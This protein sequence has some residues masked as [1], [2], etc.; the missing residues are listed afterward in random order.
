MNNIHSS[1]AADYTFARNTTVK[2]KNI[3]TG[4]ETTINVSKGMGLKELSSL[5]SK[6][7][8]SVFK[9]NETFQISYTRK[10]EQGKN[11]NV[12]VHV[13]FTEAFFD[14]NTKFSTVNEQNNKFFSGNNGNIGIKHINIEEAFIT[15]NASHNIESIRSTPDGK[16]SLS[17]NNKEVDINSRNFPKL[18]TSLLKEI[19]NNPDLGANSIEYKT[20]ALLN[21]KG[22]KFCLGKTSFGF[23]SIQEAIDMFQSYDNFLNDKPFHHKPILSNNINNKTYLWI[24]F[25]GKKYLDPESN[26][27]RDKA[28]ILSCFH[29]ISPGASANWAVGDS[30]ALKQSRILSLVLKGDLSQYGFHHSTDKGDISKF[31]EAIKL[32]TKDIMNLTLFSTSESIDFIKCIQENFADKYNLNLDPILDKVYHEAISANPLKEKSLRSD[33]KALGLEHKPMSYGEIF[34]AFVQD[35][36]SAFTAFGDYSDIAI[37]Q[38]NNGKLASTATEHLVQV[39]MNQKTGLENIKQALVNTPMDI[40]IILDEVSPQELEVKHLF[41]MDKEGNMQPLVLVGGKDTAGNYSYMDPTTERIYTGKNLDQLVKNYAQESDLPEGKI[42]SKIGQAK[43]I[44]IPFKTF[45]AVINMTE[46]A[47]MVAGILSSILPGGQYIGL[48]TLG[49]ATT[50]A[51]TKIGIKISNGEKIKNSDIYDLTTQLALLTGAGL[52][53]LGQTASTTANISNK[54]RV[55]QQ[56]A[57]DMGTALSTLGQTM[58]TL[59]D[60]FFMAKFLEEKNPEAFMELLGNFSSQVA[61]L[62]VVSSTR[63]KD[64]FKKGMQKLTKKLDSDLRHQV[65]AAKGEL[66]HSNKIMGKIP[67]GNEV[68]VRLQDGKYQVIENR[69]KDSSS[70]ELNQAEKEWIAKGGTISGTHKDG[71]QF[72][73]GNKLDGHSHPDI[74]FKNSNQLTSI[75]DKVNAGGRESIDALK[76]LGLSQADIRANG[77]KKHMLIFK[78]D[79]GSTAGVRLNI[80]LTAKGKL[81]HLT[82][83]F[84]RINSSPTEMNQEKIQSY[85][86]KEYG[87]HYG[88]HRTVTV[89]TLLAQKRIHPDTVVGIIGRADIGTP[90]TAGMLGN[91]YDSGKLHTHNQKNQSTGKPFFNAGKVNNILKDFDLKE[92]F[93]PSR[94]DGLG[95]WLWDNAEMPGYSRGL[96]S[97]LHNSGLGKENFGLNDFI[98]SRTSIKS[99]KSFHDQT[100][101]DSIISELNS[102]KKIKG[103]MDSLAKLG[104]NKLEILQKASANNPQE[105][106]IELDNG[107][108]LKLIVN[109]KIEENKIKSISVSLPNIIDKMA[110]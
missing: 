105:I 74:S 81:S 61:N 28:E 98:A 104:I 87:V 20:I 106:I 53:K 73:M 11:E 84:V 15:A 16:I 62:K 30:H 31:N 21:F 35:F 32:F 55:T 13:R 77:G 39:M 109:I 19:K 72:L 33:M 8:G 17:S 57:E 94:D 2:A 110:A 97:D 95:I 79:D 70:I 10:N 18:K 9:P 63:G 7:V 92:F 12:K 40:D 60:G 27:A 22:G 38:I 36:Q 67:S 69:Q 23:N 54:A 103:K 66:I 25:P 102:S 91:L 88:T 86:N 85:N 41:Y 89:L 4:E 34:K 48:A 68:G 43:G 29:Q 78:L 51:V 50:T 52:L 58:G 37:E 56:I 24:K 5:I 76:E 82:A 1:I 42:F 99:N 65:R 96:F 107:I 44:D 14:S 83:K 108:E 46:K 47:T 101:V 71:T 90:L 3:K 59:Q 64:Y 49:I 93:N 75:I 45:N 80:K 6:K 26:S 100:E